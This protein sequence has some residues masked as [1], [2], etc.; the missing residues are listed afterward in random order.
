MRVEY[1]P[2]LLDELEEA[3]DYYEERSE[4]LGTQFV[5][6]FERRI[7]QIASMPERWMFVRDNLRR[8]LMK[9]FPYVIYFRILGPD[10]IRVTVVKHE[11]R[12]PSYGLGRR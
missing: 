10:A 8:A 1:H 11:K 6:E 7:I 12:H 9:R 3:K 2:A 4:G 5:E